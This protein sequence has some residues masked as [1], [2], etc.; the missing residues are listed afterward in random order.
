MRQ[1]HAVVYDLEI[2]NCVPGD[3]PNDPDYAYCKGWGDKAGMGVS[4]LTAIDMWT[5]RPHIFLEDNLPD[6]QDLVAS[7]TTLIGFNSEDFDDKVMAAAGVPVKTTFDLK[8][9]LGGV[10]PGGARVKGRTLA[11]Y[12]RV[13]FPG[14][15]GKSMHGS[16]APKKWQR[17][18]WGEVIDYCMGDTYLTA[19]LVDKLPTIIDPVTGQTVQVYA[20]FLTDTAVNQL[21]IPLF[22]EQAA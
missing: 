15:E 21:P 5:G 18:E 13:N 10:L 3:G 1:I 6:F 14:A 20:P 12:L 16:E 19:K 4:V 22:G 7:R 2:I 11:D 17:K 9:A 8:K